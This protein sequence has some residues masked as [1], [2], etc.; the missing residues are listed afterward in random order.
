[1]DRINPNA[2][3]PFGGKLKKSF[4]LPDFQTIFKG[5]V[6]PD[7]AP[8]TPNEQVLSTAYLCSSIFNI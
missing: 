4:V 1:M 8:T 3:D 2:M 6:K 5:F 7:D